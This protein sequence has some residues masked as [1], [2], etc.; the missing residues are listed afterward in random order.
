MQAQLR[1]YGYYFIDDL[2]TEDLLAA[3][4]DSFQK[5]G[6]TSVTLNHRGLSFAIAS[7]ITNLERSF[8]LEQLA[9]ICNTHFILQSRIR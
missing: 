1:I 6:Q 4:N 2:L 8:L 7:E 5:L 3:I 9:E